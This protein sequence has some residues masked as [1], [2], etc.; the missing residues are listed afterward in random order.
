MDPMSGVTPQEVM[1]SLQKIS[2][3]LALR[4]QQLYELDLALEPVEG[5]YE[6][7][8]DE[9]ELGLLRK[10][11]TSDYKLPSEALRLKMARREMDAA[12]LGRYEGLKRKRKRLE[13]RIRNLGK[14][15]DSRRSILSALKVISEV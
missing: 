7:F 15:A 14:E 3:E 13:D 2:D 11:E 10:S 4:S 6:E 12:L 9:Y 1:H 5:Q 8:V